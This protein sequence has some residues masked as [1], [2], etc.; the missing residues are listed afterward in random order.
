MPEQASNK[1]EIQ[2]W[3]IHRA[4]EGGRV[5]DI[6]C[7][8]GDL[9]ARLTKEKKVRGTGLEISEAAVLKAVQRGLSVH[10]GDVEEG[11]DDYSDKAFDLALLSLTIQELSDPL[12][13]IQEAFRVAK[14]VI[15]VFPNFGHW[16][17]RWQLAIQGKSPQTKNLPYTWYESPNR[18]YL[19]VTDWETTCREQGWK[20]LEKEFLADGKPVSLW[21]NLVAEVAMYLLE[22]DG[23]AQ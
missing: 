7:G 3:I 9:L 19:T 14:R 13:V 15:I 2:Q 4:P 18:H 17:A 5:M 23:D 8:E 1:E 6:G 11:L 21:H 12:R 20:V 10:H 16:K 22:P